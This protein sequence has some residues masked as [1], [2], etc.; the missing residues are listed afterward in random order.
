M[1]TA[2]GDSTLANDVVQQER[3][4]ARW[5]LARYGPEL[6]LWAVVF[7]WASTFIAM[8]DAFTFIDPLPYTLFRFLWI[9][10]LAFAVLWAQ[11]RR[12][13]SIPL[14]IRRRDLPRFLLASIPGYTLYQICSVLGLDHS[15]VF[16]L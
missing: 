1:G 4:S 9:N 12:D 15:S 10:L 13:G 8:K 7:I 2:N 5:S 16:T 14:A 3:W 11:H 6:A